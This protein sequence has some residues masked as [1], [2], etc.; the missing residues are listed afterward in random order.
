MKKPTLFLICAMLFV[1][2]IMAQ[3]PA[4]KTTT[5]AKKP[6]T[7]S[8]AKKPVTTQKYNTLKPSETPTPQPQQQVVTPVVTTTPTP[9]PPKTT[10]AASKP[11][12]DSN[13]SDK[14]LSTY[15]EEPVK[16]PTNKKA[17]SKKSVEK[18]PVEKVVVKSSSSEAKSSNSNY[19]NSGGDKGFWIGLRGGGIMGNASYDKADLVAIDPSAK[20]DYIFGYQGGL[21]MRF[22][23]GKHISLQPEFLY[24]QKGAKLT[25]GN[26]YLKSVGNAIDVPLMLSFSFGDGGVQPFFNVGGYGSYLLDAQGTIKYGTDI[27]TQKVTFDSD[28]RRFEYGAVGGL[29]L[30]FKAGGKGKI[31]F[32]A[33]YYYGIGNAFVGKA[34]TSG[35]EPQYRNI[36][37]SIA[38]LIKL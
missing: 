36:S 35:T 14:G 11:A 28:T 21:V 23:L 24:G 19:N 33:R 6:V 27:Q 26:D 22:G 3:T 16:T 10:P 25:V 38:Y 9:P 12:G 15:N 17:N 4:K 5:P 30:A 7:K 13:Y 2:Q 37:V 8:I 1:G 31:L 18:K 32:D 34:P 29:G 20:I